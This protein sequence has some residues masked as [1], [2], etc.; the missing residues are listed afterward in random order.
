MRLDIKH[1]QLLKAIVEQGTQSKAAEQ[2]GISQSALS[3]RLAE[4]ER[5]LGFP[6]FIREGRLL[7]L[8]P[9]GKGLAQA[10]KRHLPALSEAESRFIHVAENKVP[11][12]KLGV[13]HYSC[14]HWVA[15]FVQGLPKS[16]RLLNIDFV[17]AA[18]QQPLETLRSGRADLLLYPGYY[19]DNDIEAEHLFDDELILITCPG[20]ELSSRSYIEA[21]ELQKER[22]LTYSLTKMM[23]FEF[24]RFF[25]PA[26]AVPTTLQVVEMTDAIIEL[27]SAG[28]GVSILSRWAVSRALDQ[29]QVVGVRL[30][31][32]GLFFPW[33][34]LKPLSKI[35][36]KGIEVA[37]QSLLAH[38]NQLRYQ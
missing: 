32:K 17:T 16:H 24:E 1:W 29:G 18:I 30:G 25:K 12:V 13:A 2:I 33:H 7:H 20:H 14:Y 4:A 35:E 22:F 34:L 11:S 38:F 9:A 8:T 10:A 21:V 37:C 27:V 36:E 15:Q 3:H 26:D 5:R 31:S 6:I 19:Q 28:Q 23:G